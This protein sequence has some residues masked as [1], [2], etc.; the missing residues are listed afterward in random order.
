MP[1]AANLS[2]PLLIGAAP[3]APAAGDSAAV[4]ARASSLGAR[5]FTLTTDKLKLSVADINV[6]VRTPSYGQRFKNSAMSQQ[7]VNAATLAS[8]KNDVNRDIKNFED[9]VQEIFDEDECPSF[10]NLEK[11][12]EHLSDL[13]KETKELL[14]PLEI[15]CTEKMNN[16]AEGSEQARGSERISA[17]RATLRHE[18]ENGGVS[19]LLGQRQHLEENITK[20]ENLIKEGENL[21]ESRELLDSQKGVDNLAEIYTQ[22]SDFHVMLSGAE[23]CVESVCSLDSRPWLKNSVK[24]LVVLIYLPSIIFVKSMRFLLSASNF[25][26]TF[27]LFPVAILVNIISIG[28]RFVVSNTPCLPDWLTYPLDRLADLLLKCFGLKR[29]KESFLA[30]LYTIIDPITFKVDASTVP[31][32]KEEAKARLQR[33]PLSLRAFWDI[34]KEDMSGNYVNRLKACLGSFSGANSNNEWKTLGNFFQGVLTVPSWEDV[35]GSLSPLAPSLDESDPLDPSLEPFAEAGIGSAQDEIALQSNQS[36]LVVE[37]KGFQNSWRNK[38]VTHLWSGEEDGYFSRLSKDL[39]RMKNLVANCLWSMWTGTGGYVVFGDENS[40]KLSSDG[41]TYRVT[42]KAD[43]VLNFIIQPLKTAVP[44]AFLLAACV[45]NVEVLNPIKGFSALAYT[46]SHLVVNILSASYHVAC[47]AVLLPL[48]FLIKACC[49]DLLFR[50]GWKNL[51]DLVADLENIIVDILSAATCVGHIVPFWLPPILTAIFP[52]L[53]GALAGLYTAGKIPTFLTR[54]WSQNPELGL[55]PASMMTADQGIAAFNATAHKTLGIFDFMGYACGGFMIY[56]SLKRE[57]DPTEKE[58]LQKSLEHVQNEIGFGSLSGSVLIT[59]FF[60]LFAEA[61]LGTLYFSGVIDDETYK[62]IETYKVAWMIAVLPLFGKLAA[63]FVM[64][65]V[66]SASKGGVEAEDVEQEIANL[67]DQLEIAK[68]E[69]RAAADQAAAAVAD[70]Q[71]EARAA[72]EAAQAQAEAAA[73]SAAASAAAKAEALIEKNME[74]LLAAAIQKSNGTA[75]AASAQA[76]GE[77]GLQ[78][79]QTNT[80]MQAMD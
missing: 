34:N 29:F 27:G 79:A 62:N 20:L 47:A 37:K 2:E 68:A 75:Q 56:L 25:L 26:L 6:V 76:D 9:R 11:V 74:K 4:E 46:V 78:P 10:D 43:K 40:L 53:G 54:L 22:S 16:E 39:T 50:S 66:N 8:K 15:E 33:A 60:H 42:S 38:A 58:R 13:L 59:A 48:G 64:S 71:A 45:I 12:Q 67:R 61:L 72:I 30:V 41:L 32:S 17:A 49:G 5:K 21:Q 36:N 19:E 52:P 77:A 14:K 35:K 57:T 44:L 7:L 80:E 51:K 3:L 63:T 65:K 73:E 69:A 23:S 28:L 31:C 1:R 55:D 24:A 18:G 70:A